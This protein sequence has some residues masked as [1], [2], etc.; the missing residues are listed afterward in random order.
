MYNL[1]NKNINRCSYSVVLHG[2]SIHGLSIIETKTKLNQVNIKINS[3]L[4]QRSVIYY[5][6]VDLVMKAD[7]EQ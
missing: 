1:S 2:I 7:F 4:E 6:T 5:V 3:S